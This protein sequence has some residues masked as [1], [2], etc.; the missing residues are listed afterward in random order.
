[1]D[2]LTEKFVGYAITIGLSGIVFL[3]AW[4]MNEKLN[5]EGHKPYKW[6]YFQSI[7]LILLGII[8]SVWALDYMINT[9][10][11][12]PGDL[13]F[14]LIIDGII[15]LF[16][17]LAIKKYRIGAILATL[18]TMNPVTWIISYSYFKKRWDELKPLPK[19]DLQKVPKINIK[20]F[21][22]P[23]QFRGKWASD[24]F[25]INITDTEIS[26]F[27]HQNGALSFPKDRE[28]IIGES[29]YGI[30]YKDPYSLSEVC[31]LLQNQG[32]NKI[33]FTIT[34]GVNV[35]EVRELLNRI[36]G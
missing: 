15:A 17:I 23:S 2:Y 26:I 5:P 1:M 33:M 19:L 8:I 31:I 27:E 21:N 12:G 10:S 18:I 25:T 24:H 14:L 32:E 28:E 36:N 34:R 35:V 13:L 16:A 20:M 9:Y 29:T 3:I 11:D 4:K 22:P 30:T 7:G 6:G